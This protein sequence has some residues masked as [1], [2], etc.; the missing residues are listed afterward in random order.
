MP[1]MLNRPTESRNWTVRHIAAFIAVF[2]I[3]EMLYLGSRGTPVERLVIDQLTVAPSAKLIAWMTPQEG[4]IAR[5]HSLMSSYVHLSVLNG[6]EGTEA[7]LMLAAA[8]LVFPRN[9]RSKL[10][11]IISGGV[12]IFIINQMRI[13]ALY[14]CLRFDRS[15]FEMLH[16]YVAPMVVIGAVGLYFIY[17]TSGAK[18]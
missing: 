14:Y 16:G 6:C 4:V 13:V 2:F 17:W 3:L 10:L 8:I 5:S 7:I 11:G 15:L 9:R 12:L 18:Q 1:P